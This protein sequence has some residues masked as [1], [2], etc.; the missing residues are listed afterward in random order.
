[1]ETRNTSE[2]IRNL[3]SIEKEQQE[4]DE[5]QT[6]LTERRERLLNELAESLD[7]NRFSFNAFDF[8][9]TWTGGKIRFKEKGEHYYKTLRTLLKKEGE[10]IPVPTYAAGK[11]K[12]QTISLLYRL[13]EKLRLNGFPRNIEIHKGKARITK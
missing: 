5:R 8:S 6:R 10:W 2:I 12:A 13:D 1:M 7:T 3:E 4:L 11:N 9:V